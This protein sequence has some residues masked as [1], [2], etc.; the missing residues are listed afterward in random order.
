MSGYMQKLLPLDFI[1]ISTRLGLEN[2]TE[3]G[4]R[5]GDLGSD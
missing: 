1:E 4:S 5:I 3:E 2:Y